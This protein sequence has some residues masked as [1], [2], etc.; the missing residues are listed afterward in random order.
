MDRKGQ[1]CRVIVRGKTMDSALVEF[2]DGFQAVVSRSALRKPKEPMTKTQI[3]QIL[4]DECGITKKRARSLLDTLAQTAVTEVKKNGVF[5]LPGIGRLV[6]VGKPAEKPMTKT[7]IVRALADECEITRKVARNLLDTLAQTAVTEVKKN[8]VFVLPGIG[9]LVRVDKTAEKPVTKTQIVQAL[10][11]ECGI[12]RKAVRN[13]LDT[14]AQTAATEVKKNG[15]FVVPGIGR[16]VRVDRKARAGRNS[17]GEPT[18]SPRR[19]L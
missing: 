17:A 16:L 12:T 7:Q 15:V 13:L 2:E 11:D 6:R 9:R 14:L 8:G 5:V 10:A 3:A 19:R 18:K 1:L 4:A